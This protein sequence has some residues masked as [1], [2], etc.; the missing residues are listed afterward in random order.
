LKLKLSLANKHYE[1][2]EL[3]HNCKYQELQEKML[4]SVQDLKL[5]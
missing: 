1:D 5:N 4:L 2:Q 3:K